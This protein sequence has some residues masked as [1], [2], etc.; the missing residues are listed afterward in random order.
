MRSSAFILAGAALACCRSTPPRDNHVVAGWRTGDQR[1]FDVALSV[2]AHM[3]SSPVTQ[4]ALHGRWVVTAVEV[5]ADRALLL[6]ELRDAALG[7]EHASLQ[8]EY[9]ALDRELAAPFVFAIRDDGTIGDAY[10]D[11]R[12]PAL[13]V[14][15]WRTLGSSL[16]LARGTSA[17]W[18][19]EE[20][21]ATG[22]YLARYRPGPSPGSY[23]KRK[24]RYI[25]LSTARDTRTRMLTVPI[26]TEIVDDAATLH[27][28]VDGDLDRV[29]SHELVRT[30]AELLPIEWESTLSLAR[31]SEQ[32]V[33]PPANWKQLVA[34]RER[35]APDRAFADS[36][37]TLRRDAALLGDR[38]LAD[39]LAELEAAN[40]GDRAR[41][42]A[43]A[44]LRAALRI[45]PGAIEQSRA[46]IDDDS[47]STP[48]LID[49]LGAAGTADAQ[50][51]LRHLLARSRPGAAY[52]KLAAI[53]LSRTP[54]PEVESMR[55][56]ASLLDDRALGTQATYGVGTMAR[57]F[58]EAGKDDAANAA[59]AILRDR[60]AAAHSALE[61]IIALRGIANSGAAA[62][63]PVAE[64]FFDDND[65][66]VRAA[67]VEALELM[68]DPRVDAAIAD[69]IE[70]DPS[71]SVRLAAARAARLRD[72]S[73][74]LRDLVEARIRVDSDPHVRLG[75]V[76]VLAA[77]APRSEHVAT[78]LSWV[79]EHD[80][81][82][83]VRREAQQ[84]LS[85]T[86]LV[87]A[88]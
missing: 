82:E 13:I 5:T 26:T 46:L 81:E 12:T 16:Q 50:R 83:A 53:A 48:L 73:P 24:L 52:T 59:I 30:H 68:D 25:A 63:Y 40:T 28:D 65:D 32:V 71:S 9:T 23:E 18:T 41:A 20:F 33:P 36:A 60:A 76:R 87:R 2:D 44:A 67:A 6:A 22:R 39:I 80:A 14:G 79:A 4:F 17:E 43:F 78:A 77:W 74:V 55:T 49:A 31:V 11:A 21:D 85:R 7:T 34:N 84:G 86:V 10:L 62:L 64:R 61:T 57:R 47:R 75:L 27:V 51:L 19:A 69:R 66:G 8:A 38:Q 70:R 45:R 15:I 3:A 37:N 1:A 29:A 42:N 88:P 58:G 56:L 72:P 54:D 35:Y